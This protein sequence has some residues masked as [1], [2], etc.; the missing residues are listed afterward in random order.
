MA[1]FCMATNMSPTEYW[2]LTQTQYSAFVKV[3][4]RQ[5]N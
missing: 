5:A 2:S 4:N 3:I 1:E